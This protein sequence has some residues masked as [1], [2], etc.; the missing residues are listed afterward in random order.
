MAAA[1]KV[2]SVITKK[3]NESKRA[4]RIQIK[5]IEDYLGTLSSNPQIYTSFM[6]AKSVEKGDVSAEQVVNESEEI[7][8]PDESKAGLTIIAKDDNGLFI[9]SQIIT[10][11]MK[12]KAINLMKISDV[13]QAKSKIQKFVNVIDKKIYFQRD[14]V[15]ITKPD[16]INE[17]PLRGMTPQGPITSLV[18][19]E[20]L[21][22]GATLEFDILL[23]GN[24]EITPQYLYEVFKMGNT[25]G[26]GQFRNGGYGKFIITRF[27]EIKYKDT[28]LGE[29]DK[30][31]AELKLL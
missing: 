26:L 27:D 29:L 12:D 14:G 30:E 13:K 2:E 18:A 7:N 4:F 21:S 16:G 19:S 17:R 15:N 5:L 9:Y 31:Q 23:L 11:F 20:S 1:K 6:Y 3:I 22:A 25:H 8:F 24:D 28:S 10:G